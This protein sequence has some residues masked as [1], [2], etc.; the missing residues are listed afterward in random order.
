[1]NSFARQAVWLFTHGTVEGVDIIFVHTPP[2]TV[3]SFAVETVGSLTF[4]CSEAAVQELVEILFWK[5]LK[6]EF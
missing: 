5:Q 6:R 2:T 1:V 3:W 4:C